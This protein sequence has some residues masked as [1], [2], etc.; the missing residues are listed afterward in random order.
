M[1][2][3]L[4]DYENVKTHG[5]DGVVKLNSDDFVY[6]FYSEN[7]ETLT[8]GLHRRINESKAKILYH[9]VEAKG[10]NALDFQLV[11]FLGYLIHEN[12]EKEVS[13][14]IVT[15]DQG[16]SS[17]VSYWKKKK[18]DIELV[19][20]VTGKNT[21][22]KEAESKAEVKNSEKNK[23]SE[24]EAEVRKLIKN[25]EEAKEVAKIIHHYKT[26][27]GIHNALVKKFPSKNNQKASELYTKI[28]PL[29]KEK[30][31]KVANE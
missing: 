5:L 21:Q 27:Q 16:F 29:I 17:V 24:L 9:K 12:L 14:Y 2:C 30:K 19:T 3:Y 8:F 4:V 10:K 23:E 15:K 1:N 31:G 26:K 6:I 11:S 7:A 22:N 20:D 25:K 28:K 13:Y 18:I